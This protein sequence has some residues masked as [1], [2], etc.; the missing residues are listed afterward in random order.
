MPSRAAARER[1]TFASLEEVLEMPDLLAVQKDSF[2]WFMRDGLRDVFSDIS[3]IK[4]TDGS[5]LLELVFVRVDRELT[6]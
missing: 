4:T 2:E 5:L 1:Y 6:P 3:P